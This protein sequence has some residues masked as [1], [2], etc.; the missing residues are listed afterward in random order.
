M[1]LNKIDHSKTAIMTINQK[2]NLL[3][4][5]RIAVTRFVL[6]FIAGVAISYSADAQV[7]IVGYVTNDQVYPIDYTRITHLNIAFENPDVNGNLSYSAANTKYIAEAHKHGVKVLVSIAGGSASHNPA[8][9]E[10]YFQLINDQNR[11]AFVEKLSAYVTNH[12]FDG[13]DVDLEGPAINA[14]YGEFIQELSA[15]LK[16]TG[17]LLTSALS[18]V[19]GG[20]KVPDDAMKLFDYI[21][22]MAYDA[23]G[24]WQPDLPGQHSSYE[25]ALE[26]L[27][28]WVTRGL[29]KEKAILGVPFYGYGFGDDFNEGIG[30]A[31]ILKKYPDAQDKDEVGNTIYYNGLPTIRKKTQ[32]VVDEGYGGIMIWQLAQDAAGSFSLL[33]AIAEIANPVAS[34]ESVVSTTLDI[35]PNPVDS[36][37]NLAQ[38][39]LVPGTISITDEMG[40]EYQFI[41]TPNGHLDVSALPRGVYILRL[42]SGREFKTKKFIKR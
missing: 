30:F 36:I 41:T 14:D 28:Y 32:H 22:I 33:T 17:K 20:P 19:N 39:G 15:A 12:N 3:C 4:S 37:L 13:L 21:N 1:F 11:A 7:K 6:S 5:K 16:G 8:V 26:S 29:P 42:T 2:F 9:Q 27:E 38:M 24:P 18:H 25:F 31:Q 23:T 10:R 34:S 35:Y 40:K